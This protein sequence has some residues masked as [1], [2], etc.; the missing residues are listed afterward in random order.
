MVCRDAWDCCLGKFKDMNRPSEE[1]GPVPVFSEGDS[2]I[3]VSLGDDFW[4]NE[5]KCSK[6]SGAVPPITLLA[7]FVAEDEA[8]LDDP[9]SGRAESVSSTLIAHYKCV[10]GIT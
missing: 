7:D 5:L 4:D 9:V 3:E 2:N 1:R 6:S 10:S 8:L